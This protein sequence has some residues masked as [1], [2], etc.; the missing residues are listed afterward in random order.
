MSFAIAGSHLDVDNRYTNLDVKLRLYPN[1]QVLEGFGI[2]TSLGVARI[3][4]DGDCDGFDEI[5]GCQR[6]SAKTFSTPSS[7]VGYG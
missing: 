7:A 2:A 4:N 1:D 5:G 3:R 6:T